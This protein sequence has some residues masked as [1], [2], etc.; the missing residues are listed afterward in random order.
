MRCIRLFLLCSSICQAFQWGLGNFISQR[1][2]HRQS[3]SRLPRNDQGFHRAALS[4]LSS[5]SSSN[6][7]QSL[8]TPPPPP[9]P[10]QLGLRGL[11]PPSTAYANGTLAV[12]DM[13]TLYWE[14]HG[15]GGPKDDDNNNDEKN[16]KPLLN[17]LFLHGGPG[18]GCFPNHARFFDPN[19]YRIVLFDQRGAGRSTP[20]GQVAQNTLLDIVHDCERLRVHL[21]E[22]EQQ[23]NSCWDV[24][25]GGSWGTT[26]AVAYAQEFPTRMRALVLRG[27]CL[28]RPQEVD[29]L[30]SSQG[31]VAQANPESW[32]AFAQAVNAT[33]KN[34]RDALRAYYDRL[35]CPD[36]SIRLPAAKAWMRWE[37]S[38][39]ASTSSN[40][41]QSDELYKKANAPVAVGQNGQW[42]WLDGP[43]SAN[44]LQEYGLTDTTCDEAVQ[45]LCHDL[46][47]GNTFSEPQSLPRTPRAIE[48]IVSTNKQDEDISAE[49][50][51]FVPAQNILT[52]F[53]SVNDRYATNNINLLDPRRMK[54]LQ[55]IP[56]IAVHGGLDRVCPVDT[57]VEL[58][59]HWHWMELRI[60]TQSGHSMYDVAITNQLICATDE[61]AN[62]LLV[63]A[64]ERSG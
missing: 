46:E 32:K 38:A 35:L 8:P 11:Y 50:A 59:L 30:F 14:V 48:Y 28:M 25:M 33:E 27:I 10:E 16:Q 58:Q 15:R 31:G 18:A 51:A 55:H 22:S 45:R 63:V 62:R 64:D 6:N 1:R 7:E 29:W 39:F 52:C 47:K 4:P 21:L 3:L 20:R 57:A 53:Y 19:V 36:P 40:A 5:S 49:A 56:C 43:G 24:V 2:L 61:L 42:H 13:H 60:P 41:T 54:A 37:F 9:S 26:V 17:A 44:V 12:D 34:P 23:Q